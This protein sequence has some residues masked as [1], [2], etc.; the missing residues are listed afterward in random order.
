MK[1]YLKA[2]I[3]AF[4]KLSATYRYPKNLIL[5]LLIS[6]NTSNFIRQINGYPNKFVYFCT[7]YCDKKDG[8]RQGFGHMGQSLGMGMG[9][10][11]ARI[12][13]GDFFP[14]LA[15]EWLPCWSRLPSQWSE[16]SLVHP[17]TP[18]N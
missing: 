17:T 6:E 11:G 5:K 16:P 9:M 10:A 18:P 12:A 4:L 2:D 14:Q 13:G 8:V 15:A 7:T 3:S 1:A